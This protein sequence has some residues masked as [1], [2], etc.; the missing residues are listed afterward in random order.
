MKT[1]LLGILIMGLAISAKAVDK[2]KLEDQLHSLTDQ[3]TAMQQNPSTAVPAEQLAQAKGIIL[4]DR[5]R[6]AFMFG[7][8]SGNGVALTRDNSGK[9]SAVGFVSSVGASLGAQIGGTKDFYVILLMTPGAVDQLRQSSMDFGAEASGTGGSTYAG[10]Q[11]SMKTTPSVLVYSAR[12]GLYAGA[13][14]KGGSIS[15]DEDANQVYYGRPVSMD[16]ILFSHQVE[17]TPATA[18][19]I[20]KIDQ[21]SK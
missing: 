6:G 9:W 16:D 1:L 13:A 8:H 18:S 11:A 14:I 20:A 5:T 7:F 21:Y 2:M 17:P 3:F 4:L 10:A 12:N 15:T 19:L